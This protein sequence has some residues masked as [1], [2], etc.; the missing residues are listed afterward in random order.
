MSEP[1][2]SILIPVYNAGEYLRPSV[3]S[4]LTQS[5]VN[6][7]ILL[8]DD[9]STD[10]CV[11]SIAH[12][13]DP[14]LRVIRQNNAGRA[15]AL[16]LG[17]KQLSGEFYVTQDADDISHPQRIE[18]QVRCMLANPNLAAVF[19]GHEIILNGRSFAPLSGA[20]SIE[21]CHQDIVHLHMP[22]LDPTG[23]FRVSIVRDIH[24]E[25]TLKVG[26]G[27]DYILRVG[28]LY[29]MMV[30]GECLY[31]Y[32]SHANSVTMQDPYRER[33]M[34]REVV[35]RACKRRGLD[36]SYHLSRLPAPS[37]KLTHAESHGW[38]IAHFMQSVLD[39]RSANRSWE[40]LKTALMC[41]CMRPYDP[42]YYKPLAYFLSPLGIVKYYRTIKA[43]LK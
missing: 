2:V 24:Y 29:P 10:S 22:T 26:A 37:A 34:L 25:P 1:L 11:E 21:Q 6:L 4:V 19:T 43:V 8:I 3:Q 32:R 16:N 39:L 18:H 23:M 27:L 41:L 31:S 7:E 35:R 17:L 36:S 30:L 15:V 40:A 5:Y 38:L 33:Q 12:I 20:K 28:E 9:G 14:R 42:H 13:S